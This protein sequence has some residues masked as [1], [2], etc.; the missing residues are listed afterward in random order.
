M[1]R[2]EADKTDSIRFNQLDKTLTLNPNDPDA[3]YEKG[4]IL[5][6]LCRDSEALEYFERALKQDPSHMRSWVGK[7]RVFTLQK[8][9]DEAEECFAKVPKDDEIHIEAQNASCLN[10][11][12]DDR[13]GQ[14]SAK[15]TETAYETA[16]NDELEQWMSQ[17]ITHIQNLKTLLNKFRGARDGQRRK[18]GHVFHAEL[19]R[20]FYEQDSSPK[21][22]SVERNDIERCTTDVDIELEGNIFI[23]AWRGAMPFDYDLGNILSK[24]R[25]RFDINWCEELEPVLKKLQQLPSKIGKGFVINYAPNTNGLEPSPLYKFCTENKCVMMM[26]QDRPH[27]IVYGSSDFKYKDEACQIARTLGRPLRFLLGDWK[28][29]QDQGRDPIA[30]SAYGIDMSKP[31][32]NKLCNMNKDD[33]LKYATQHL[34]VPHYENLIDLNRDALLVCVLRQV[35]VQD[36]DC[37]EDKPQSDS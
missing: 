5:L 7:G 6:R 30:E 17:H 19:V 31:L 28:K 13:R 33:L 29:L 36:N 20:C 1:P 32:Y 23:Q 2:F 8:K 16:H 9:Y 18:I 37:P 22:I 26:R 11:W 10:K 24:R 4:E 15:I 25:D 35:S 14:G 3:N 21:V 27:I 34:K 12:Y